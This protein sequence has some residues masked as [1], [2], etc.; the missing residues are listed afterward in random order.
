[1]DIPDSEAGKTDFEGV[2]LTRNEYINAIIH[3]YRGERS[4]ADG[5]RERLDSTTNWAVFSAGGMLSFTFSNPE[6]SHATLLLGQLLIIVFL[7]IEAR[8][9]RVFD[10]WR[11]RVRMLE[12]NFFI[13]ILRRNLVSPREEWRES[14]ARDLDHPKFKMSFWLALGMRLRSNY[15]WIL[16]VMLAAWLTK[17]NI[18]PKQ[19]ESFSQVLARMGI[20]FMPGWMVALT[21]F[22]AYS[23]GIA[24]AIWS[25]QA[26]GYDEVEG[27]ETAVED[28]KT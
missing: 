10:V 25:S 4:R 20:G 26:R 18:H 16:L 24:I 1:M 11:A 22:L 3:F 19:A 7:T 21:I 28:W 15:L 8:R 12:E 14:V 13:P 5:W 2:P 27:M 9:F 23:I 17:I 6:H